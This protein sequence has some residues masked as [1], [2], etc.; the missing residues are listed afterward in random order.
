M[1]V[2]LRGSA[3]GLRPAARTPSAGGDHLAA[4]AGGAPGDV[5][6]RR[7][8]Q[9]YQMLAEAEAAPGP[10][11]EVN[12]AVAHGPWARAAGL[13]VLAGVD[14]ARLGNSPLVPTIR[15]GPSRARRVSRRRG[16]GVHRG[17]RTHPQ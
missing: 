7:T 14:S 10:V 9:L 16:R 5:D 11:I 1:V 12:R 6:L 13:A 8:A 3:Y 4:R 2:R 17:G 15:G